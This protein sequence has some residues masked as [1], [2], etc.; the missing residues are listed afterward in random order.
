MSIR[1]GESN[2]IIRVSSN[3]YDM[4]SYTELKLNFTAPGGGTDFEAA[5]ADGVVLGTSNVVDADLGSL[6]ANE[7]LEYPITA[8]DFDVDGDWIVCLEYQDNTT[9]PTTIFLGE[10]KEFEVLPPC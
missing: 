6:Q 4:S 7:Y 2:K 10:D 9:S 1:R 5:T 8:T 3:G